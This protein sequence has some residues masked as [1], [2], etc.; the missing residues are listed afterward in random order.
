MP[1]D[2]YLRRCINRGVE[3]AEGAAVEIQFRHRS[4]GEE[5][6]Y[7]V[8]RSWFT[9]KSGVSERVEVTRNGTFDRILTDEWNEI[10][11]E[12]IPASISH[13][14]FFDGEK[15][16]SFADIENSARLL[17]NAVHSLLGLDLVERLS[18]DLQVLEGRQRARLRGDADR[19]RLDEV[20]AAWR[21]AEETRA[22]AV[23][24]TRPAKQRLVDELEKELRSAE[25]H[26]MAEGGRLLD[27]V[28]RI[29]N[30]KAQLEGLLGDG[31]RRAKELAAGPAPLLLVEDLLLSAAAQ[32]EA[33]ETSK[34]ASSLGNVLTERDS[35]ILHVVSGQKAP[36]AVIKALEKY[37]TADRNMRAAAANSSSYLN[38][39]QE[40]YVSLRGLTHASSL[41]SVRE[42]V[43]QQLE[44]LEGLHSRLNDTERKLAS[45]PA[46]ESLAPLLAQL[47]TLR[48][49]LGQERVRLAALDMDIERLTR[50]RDAK[51]MAWVR[52]AERELDVKLEHED[53]NRIL[54]HSVR[55]RH[56]LEDFKQKVVRRHVSRI[57]ELVLDS[58]RQL[59]RKKSLISELRID[60]DHFTIEL[61]GGDGQVISPDRLSA[62][63]RQLMAVSLL[64]GLARASGRPLPAVIDTPLGRLDASHRLKLIERYFPHASHQVLLLSTDEE[65]DEPLY[66]KLRPWVGRTYRLDFDDKQNVTQPYSGYFW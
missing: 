29:E 34:R 26:Y 16:E 53:A 10:V 60:P 64:W 38:L 61:R 56:T 5:H 47:D 44:T 50:E 57:E 17:N 58:F 15:I 23:K 63:E 25:E 13:L 65:I 41:S 40:G 21:E 1:Y 52:E 36:K 19:R 55:I 45:I 28:P 43:L 22:K 39:N 48:A 12:F 4:E 59:L 42:E 8:H 32:A 20:E 35:Q 11:D 31:A 66:E 54:T 2:E 46:T 37:L 24:D 6:T 30:D 33:E 18:T 9:G 62:G 7:R 51:K 27:E 49:T 3:P 14:F